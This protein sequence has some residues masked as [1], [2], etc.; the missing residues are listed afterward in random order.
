M[1][2]SDNIFR[3]HV[4]SWRSFLLFSLFLL[5]ARFTKT[6]VDGNFMIPAWLMDSICFIQHPQHCFISNENVRVFI[7]SSNSSL[8]FFFFSSP[9]LKSF[10]VTRKKSR[11]V[12]SIERGLVVFWN[13]IVSKNSFQK[14]ENWISKLISHLRIFSFF[15]HNLFQQF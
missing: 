7:Y 5:F 15:C 6:C 8:S 2:E 10:F 9:K 1:D 4:A 14:K 3:K 11:N 12:I 13:S